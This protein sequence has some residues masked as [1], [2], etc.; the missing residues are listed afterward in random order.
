MNN[1]SCIYGFP[2]GSYSKE[3]ACNAGETQVLSLGWEDPLDKEMAAH[4]SVLTWR[5]PWT[6]KP[7]V[8][9]SMGREESD[10]TEQLIPHLFMHSSID[11]L[12][13]ISWLL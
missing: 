12:S 6:E 13:S 11:G 2:G 8:H 10:T 5:I 7:G 3:S 1:I 9:Q 4:P